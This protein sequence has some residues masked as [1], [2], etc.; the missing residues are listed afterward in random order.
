MKRGV[1]ESAIESMAEASDPYVVN[2]TKGSSYAE[3]NEF[4]DDDDYI[5]SFNQIR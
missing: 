4:E 2:Q 3:T 1:D 5:F